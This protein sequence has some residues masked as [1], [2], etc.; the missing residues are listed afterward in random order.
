MCSLLFWMARPFQN[1]FFSRS[2]IFAL[3]G[4]HLIFAKILIKSVCI[5]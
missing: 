3:M 1:E 2:K 5:Q 4:A